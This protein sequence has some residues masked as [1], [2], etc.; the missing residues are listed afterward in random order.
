MK[1][2]AV[3]REFKGCAFKSKPEV[4][5]FKVD[6]YD[7]MLL[8]LMTS[9]CFLFLVPLYSPSLPVSMSLYLSVFIFVL[10]GKNIGRQ[11]ATRIHEQKA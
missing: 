3:G 2:V 5:H 6:I 9:F 11:T 1:Q 4:I 8:P 10:L 7:E